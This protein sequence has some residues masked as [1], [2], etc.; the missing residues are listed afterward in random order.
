ML[1]SNLQHNK[2]YKKPSIKLINDFFLIIKIL[3]LIAI[4]VLIYS[5]FIYFI[6]I[7]IKEN[8]RVLRKEKKEA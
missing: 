1:S 8:G 2:N 7:L 3:L 4:I 6:L 5:F